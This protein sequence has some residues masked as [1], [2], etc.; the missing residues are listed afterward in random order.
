MKSIPLNHDLVA[1]VDDEDFNYLNQFRWHVFKCKNTLYARRNLWIPGMQK[2]SCVLMHREI[3]RANIGEWIDHIDRDGLN[4]QKSNLRKCTQIEN[5]ANSSIK[6]NN[7]SGFKGVSWNKGMKKWCAQI[8]SRG[9][10]RIIGYFEDP[11]VAAAAYDECLSN[12][13][14]EFAATNHKLGLLN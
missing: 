13:F 9:D 11:M 3:L 6:R 14:G 12:L 5:I 8:E 10:H 1:L 2:N 4:N 7:K